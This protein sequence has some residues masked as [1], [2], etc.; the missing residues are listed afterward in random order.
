MST[1]QN[2]T[3]T[4]EQLKHD[5]MEQSGKITT[6]SME[7]KQHETAKQNL[8]KE[9]ETKDALQKTREKEVEQLKK[10]QKLK[11]GEIQKLKTEIMQLKNKMPE[12]DRAH[13]RVAEEVTQIRL[14]QNKDNLELLRVQREVQASMKIPIKK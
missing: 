2:L 10:D 13:R 14:Q 6:K 8:E 3:Q 5:L 1:S 4:L 9:I 11:E 12:I 7:L